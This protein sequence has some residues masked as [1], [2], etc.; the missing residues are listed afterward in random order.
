MWVY[1]SLLTLSFL[2]YKIFPKKIYFSILYSLMAIVAGTR[3]I[4]TG[5]DTAMYHRIFYYLYNE[6][7]SFDYFSELY[8]VEIGNR[9]LIYFVSLFS[10]DPQAYLMITAAITTFFMARFIYSNSTDQS[11]WLASFLL[12]ALGPY[13]FEFNGIRQTL[14]IAIAA[15]SLEYIYSKSYI[16]SLCFILIGGLFH[17]SIFFMIPFIF[18]IKYFMEKVEE[19]ISIKKIYFCCFVGLTLL[20]VS[21]PLLVNV[22]LSLDEKFAPYAAV[23]GIGTGTIFNATGL[24]MIAIGFILIYMI[25]FVRIEVQRQILPITIYTMLALFL[26]IL[27]VTYMDMIFRVEMIFDIYICLFV[28]FFIYEIRGTEYRLFLLVLTILGGYVSTYYSLLHGFQGIF[29][30]L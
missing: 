7:I 3:N 23:I 4:D 28:T 30:K 5:I 2:G 6:P 1:L 26:Y 25:L 14:G 10:D 24:K 15:N 9:F 21:I 8:V 22:F 16:K 18:I 11:Y 29:Q 17:V 12:I 13:F 19:G 20:L 27:Q